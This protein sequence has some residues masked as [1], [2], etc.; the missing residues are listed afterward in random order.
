MLILYILSISMITVVLLPLLKLDYWLFRVFD[1]PRIQKFAI[2]LML[3]CV[4]VFII[5]EGA[6]WYE[7]TMLTFLLA[8][9]VHLAYLIYPF[10]PLGKE[11]IGKMK[12]TAPKRVL[13]VLVANVYQENRNYHLLLQLVA[14]RNPDIVFL[15]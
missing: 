8:C 11:M 13:N 15:L 9:E 4:W 5:Y 7:W 6:R 12:P 1:Y 14:R 3:C 2:I 10:T